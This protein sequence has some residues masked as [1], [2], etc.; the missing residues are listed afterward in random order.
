MQWTTLHSISPCI[1]YFDKFL[2]LSPLL[3]S[4]FSTFRKDRMVLNKIEKLVSRVDVSDFPVS[5]IST[6]HSTKTHILNLILKK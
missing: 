1:T 2:Q 5:L 4:Q 6:C 3:K